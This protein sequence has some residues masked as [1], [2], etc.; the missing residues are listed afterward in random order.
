MAYAVDRGRD[1]LC[2]P[3]RLLLESRRI[4]DSDLGFQSIVAGESA[5]MIRSEC[6]KA[7]I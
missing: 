6:Q 5:L 7:D 4:N 2:D 1:I 3:N